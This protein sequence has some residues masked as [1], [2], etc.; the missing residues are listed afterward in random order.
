MHI[1]TLAFVAFDPSPSI[2]EWLFLGAS[3]IKPYLKTSLRHYLLAE[4]E[5]G[6][7]V[8]DGSNAISELSVCHRT[9]TFE[10]SYRDSDADDFAVI[11]RGRLK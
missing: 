9:D 1:F 3:S 7:L 11:R 2:R 8:S 5:P 6:L 10:I 4:I